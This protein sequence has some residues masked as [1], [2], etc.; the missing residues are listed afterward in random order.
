MQTWTRDSHTVYIS[1]CCTLHFHAG[2]K[3]IVEII[4]F[5]LSEFILFL[6]VLQITALP[7]KYVLHITCTQAQNTQLCMHTYIYTIDI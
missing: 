6:E 4:L 5:D 2:L 3:F 1:I 7:Y